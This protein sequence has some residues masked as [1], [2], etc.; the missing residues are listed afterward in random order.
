MS[1]IALGNK[2]RTNNNNGSVT[3]SLEIALSEF[4]SVLTDDERKQ[5]QLN[6]SVPDASAA[7]VFTARLDA[8]NS[9]RRGK[10]IGARAYSMLQSIQQFSAIV[11]TFISANPTIAALIWGSVKLTVLIAANMTS[12]FESLADLFM[13]LNKHFPQF[14]EYKLLFPKSLA[15]QESICIFHASIVQLCKQTSFAN[16]EIEGVRKMTI[17]LRSKLSPHVDNI[18]SCAKDVKKAIALAKATSDRKEQES[19]EQER[20][21]AAEHRK[22]FSIFASRSRK[23]LECVREW[24]IQREQ[25][26]LNETLGLLVNV[27]ISKELSSDSQKA[28]DQHGHMVVFNSRICQVKG[29]WFREDRAYASTPFA[30]CRS[31][32]NKDFRSSVID[33]LYCERTRT[34]ELTTFVFPRFD[35]SISLDAAAVLRSIIR[36]TLEPDNVTGEVERQLGIFKN[37]DADIDTIKTL[38]QHCISRFSKLYI[39]IDALDEFEKEQRNTLLRSLSFIISL[40]GSKAKLFLVGRSSVLMDIRR[41]FPASQEKSVDCREVQADIEVYTRENIALR[42]EEQLSSQ[43]QLILQDPALA[44]EIIE[45]LING[46]DG[47]FLWVDYQITEICEC[48]CDDEVR[49]VLRTPPRNLGETFDRATNRIMK[50][51]PAKIAGRI[52]QWVAAAK[53]ALTLDELREALS[54]E[55]GTPYSIAG[56]RPNGLE[57]I[58]TWCENLVQLDEEL[59]IVQFAHRSVLLHFLEQPSDSSLQSFHINPE[60]ADHF[61]G[62]ICVTYLNSNEFKTDLIRNS[63][64]LPTQL[65]DYIIEKALEGRG[66]TTRMMGMIQRPKAQSQQKSTENKESMVMIKNPLEDSQATLQSGH[67]FLEYAS[68]YWLPHTRNFEEGKSTT[69]NLW[70]Q[71]I[72]GEHGLARTPWSPAEFHDRTPLVYGWLDKHDHL[73]VF[74]QVVSIARLGS[75]ER[76]NLICRYAKLGCLNYIKFLISS[77]SQKGELASG[78][79]Y[80]ARGGHLEVVQRLLDAKADVNAALGYEGW[81]A[82][83]GQTALQAA[84]RGGHLEVVQRLLDAKANVNAATTK[85][86]GGRTVLQAAAGGGHLEVVQRLLDAKADVNATA[87]HGGRTA[88]QAAAKGGHLE[89]VALLKSFGARN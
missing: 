86:Y 11:D 3:K 48:T 12:Y 1:V 26:L 87:E 34:D 59:Q 33:Y 39:V 58:T 57:R 56:K 51:G 60:E 76:T 15:L 23:K 79:T 65:P 44:Q 6:K 27:R 74:L 89:V 25:E 10:S 37:S 84:A 28:A 80:A 45:A 21:I 29:C 54:Y 4:G 78:L 53:R 47:M 17:D 81:T 73:A 18:H 67:P 52:F 16:P 24:Q 77:V 85:G 66:A 30:F 68:Y 83:G 70:K 63:P 72:R 71:M 20:E 41:L 35:D 8:S 32:A 49:E 9:N 55:P 61:V 31:F 88:L 50:R 42:Q 5:L 62:E 43:E 7:L 82:Y 13:S 69:W 14:D 22:Q 75:I 38:L 19:Q 40:P 46:A 2:P 36:Q 64:A